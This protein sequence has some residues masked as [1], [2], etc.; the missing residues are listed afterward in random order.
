MYMAALYGEA[1]LAHVISFKLNAMML[2][3]QA[4]DTHLEA[5]GGDIKT[6]GMSVAILQL[7]DSD[8]VSLA[9]MVHWR[10]VGTLVAI[11]NDN[12]LMSAKISEM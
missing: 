5:C 4:G 12:A 9:L 3:R 6:C 11:T 7:C 2:L 1:T 8:G 10:N